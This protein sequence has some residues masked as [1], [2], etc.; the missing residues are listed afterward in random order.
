MVAGFLWTGFRQGPK[1]SDWP[2]LETAWDP[3]F[4]TGAGQGQGPD[5][6]R[7]GAGLG[8]D[9]DRTG[10]GLESDWSRTGTGLGPDWDRKDQ[11]ATGLEPDWGDATSGHGSGPALCWTG[12][13]PV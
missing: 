10:T 7:T 4:R 2:A 11:T 3:K 1:G 13:T 8:P 6:D 12:L 9:W 5:W